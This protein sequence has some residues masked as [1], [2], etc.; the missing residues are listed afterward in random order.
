MEKNEDY[1][2]Q[3]L[4][5]WM[6]AELTRHEANEIL[7]YLKTDDSSRLLLKK[8]QEVFK[9]SMDQ[10]VTIPNDISERVQNELLKKIGDAPV[11]EIPARN[12]RFNWLRIAAAALIVIGLGSVTYFTLFKKS[13]KNE[14]TETTLPVEKDNDVEAGSNKAVLTLADGTRIELDE[15]AKGSL[16]KRG[17]VSVTNAEGQLIYENKS[18][19]PVKVEYNSLT[20]ARG[21]SYSLVL[22]DGSKLWLNAASSVRFPTAFTGNERRVE[23][24]GEVYFDVAKDATRPFHVKVKDMDIEVLGTQFNINSYTDE[25]TINTTLIEGSVKV[26][27]GI[28]DMVRLSPGQQAQFSTP[29][30][31][32]V[33]KNVNV[34][35]IVAWKNGYFHFENADLR[36]ILRQF[37][38]W[39]DI[40]VVFEGEL[41]NRT[42]LA[43]VS[44]KSSLS[45]VL[46][47]LNANDV[48]FRIEGK[49]LIVQS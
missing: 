13:T 39:Y 14:F 41:K 19:I 37:S 23:I 40:E 16:L 43:I 22:A 18:T 21:Q 28:N 46:K 48:K 11:I 4:E 26:S 44:R 20:S 12:R 35:E 30:S 2:R 31:L 15:K 17:D 42:F 27:S 10:P 3:L 1:Y 45:N 6:R 29:G 38:R 5:K 32:K 25:A 9:Q 34:D 36:S 47:M 24:T 8:M 49:K 33:M 7:D